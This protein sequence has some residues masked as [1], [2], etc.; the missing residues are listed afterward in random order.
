[1]FVPFVYRYT[2]VFANWM[3][4]NK[5][6]FL[7]Q[8][9]EKLCSSLLAWELMESG[10]SMKKSGLIFYKFNYSYFYVN[11]AGFCPR[12][13]FGWCHFVD[14]KNRISAVYGRFFPQDDPFA[15]M[16]KCPNFWL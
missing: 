8:T 12:D 16:H 2:V 1:M 10:L 4:R 14:K 15:K 7:P 9:E 13:Y 6:Y 5:L 3:E 11:C